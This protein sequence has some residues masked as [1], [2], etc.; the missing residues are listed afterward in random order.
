MTVR[1]YRWILFAIV[2]AFLL[3]RAPPLI[4][5]PGRIDEECYAVPGMTILQ[6]GLPQLPHMP[7]RNPSSMFY[8]A[9]EILYAEPPL[10]FYL[11]SIF[12][13]VLPVSYPTGRL[14]SAVSSAVVLCLTAK[15]T[16]RWTSS[17]AAGLWAAGL[18][19]LSR[20]FH[21]PTTLAR[22]DMLC[23]L[24]GVAAILSTDQWVRT[25]HRRWLV[26]TGA[27]LGF[28]GLTL[29]LAL[30]MAILIAGWV[31][32]ES[33]GI[34]RLVHPV[35]IA[36]S[37]LGVFSLWWLLIRINPDV[38]RVQFNNQ[39]LGLGSDEAL[40]WIKKPFASLAYH[41]RFL[42]M[43]IGAYQFLLAFGA[44][45]T[46]TIV[47]FLSPDANRI[48]LS[49]LTW[50][51]F[52]LLSLI[53]GRHHDIP[54]YW[55]FTGVLLFVCIGWTIAS[56]LGLLEKHFERPGRWL[57]WTGGACLIV[58]MIPGSGARLFVEYVRH[59]ND[60]N[61]RGSLFAKAIMNDLP[62]NAICVVDGE[63]VLDFLADGRPTLA[64]PVN[65]IFFDATDSEYDFLVISRSGIQKGIAERMRGNLIRSYGDR[66]DEFACYA[67]VYSPSDSTRPESADKSIISPGSG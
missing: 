46:T 9:D 40:H 47:G 20:W 52:L 43:N 41:T 28:G 49:T 42:W 3:F 15:L 12:Y 4:H 19:G 59:W 36:V 30:V 35:S 16:V 31:L 39:F 45:L 21:Y 50:G 54:G 67:E 44:A 53:V 58:L 34:G 18:L 27:I 61:Y 60:E 10:Y 64:T 38:F 13:A 25:Q 17:F 29:P 55:A 14:L 48:R 1:Q 26:V 24:F 66:N 33:R 22:P 8:R 37:S 65:P 62:A 7:S 56:T 6:T 63:Y 23:T 11:Q 57:G 51:S 5:Q 32:V 2:V